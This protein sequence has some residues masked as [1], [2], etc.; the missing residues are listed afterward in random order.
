[1]IKTEY[2]RKINKSSLI[3]I[4]EKEDEEERD[5][6]GMFQYNEIPYFL[7]ME[8]QRTGVEL[9]FCYDITGKRSLEQLLE[10]QPLDYVLLQMILKAFDQACM[11][12]GEYMMTENDILLEPEFVFTDHSAEQ[13]SYCY[14]P[15][16]QKDICCQFKKFMEYLL[17]Y[18]DHN[19]EQA[20]QLA[21]GVYQKVVE[22]RTAL[23]HVLE[24]ESLFAD[25]SWKDRKIPQNKC[26]PQS[27][28]N[29]KQESRMSLEQCSEMKYQKN[30]EQ[31]G[32]ILW[33]QCHEPQNH[34]NRGKESQIFR[35]GFHEPQIYQVQ[36]SV[37]QIYHKGKSDELQYEQYQQKK[38]KETEKLNGN[39][40][41][42]E[43]IKQKASVRKQ[44]A[45]KLKKMLQKKIYTDK[46]RY[47]E[48]EPVFEAEEEEVVC[49]NP[50]VCLISGT[51]EI[52]NRFVYQGTDRSR[53]FHCLQGNM[54][55][56]SDAKESDI[57][58]PFPMVSRIHARIETGNQG[59]FLED[60]NSTNGTHVNGELLKYREKRL[61]QKGDLISLA[62]ECY[63]FH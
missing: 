24:D 51:E 6:I 33:E 27:Q 40:E 45:E 46:S 5:S 2:T 35:N 9:K 21:Y 41:E 17:P 14:L 62:G 39:G 38:Q 15:G 60:L 12:T 37:S 11:Q 61:L 31:E 50:T 7:K 22:E 23:H 28:Q 59:T 1:M 4:P 44:A 54:L 18:V 3:I 26:E 8:A 29:N 34:N 49:N 52:Q 48:E 55:L 13:V 47:M 63:S 19:N 36:E 32:Q 56:G 25:W 58:I 20:M 42:V 30:R 43:K 57:Y 53:D 16:N 10:Y